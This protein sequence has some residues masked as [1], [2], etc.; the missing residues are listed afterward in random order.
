MM[1]DDLIQSIADRKD[2][3]R[4]KLNDVRIKVSVDC[5]LNK[6]YNKP[7]DGCFKYHGTSSGP[8]FHSDI[9]QDFENATETKKIGTVDVSV[10]FITGS[11]FRI[12][13]SH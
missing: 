10:K 4:L 3:F 8:A 5:F 6:E 9:E 12:Y 11:I 1:A 7:K 13:F 2:K